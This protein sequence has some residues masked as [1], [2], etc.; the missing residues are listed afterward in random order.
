[1]GDN[2]V[3]RRP[4][5]FLAGLPEP[6][7][8]F[9]V[10]AVGFGL[11]FAA[12]TPPL[13]AP[14]EVAHF[15]RAEGISRGRLRAVRTAAGVGALVPGEVAALVDGPW[16]RLPFHPEASLDVAEVG[17]ALG[18]GY[19]SA[20]S[21]FVPFPATAEY[22]PLPYLPQAAGVAAARVAG[23]PP[24]LQYASGRVAALA[25][26]LALVGLAVRTAPEHRWTIALAAL[27][28]MSLFLAASFSADGATN[29]L[30]FLLL[31]QCLRTRRRTAPMAWR[32]LATVTAVAAGLMLAKP[33]VPLLLLTWLA[34]A[35]RFGSRLRHL[36]FRAAVPCVALLPLAA[37]RLAL[38]GVSPWLPPGV[39]PP[40]QLAWL[41]AHPAAFGRTLAATLAGGLPSWVNGWVGVLGW[42][43]TPLPAALVVAEVGLVLLVGLSERLPAGGTDWGR[44]AILAAA[45]VG[46]AGAVL[47]TLYLRWTPVAA[48]VVDG[49]QGRYFAPLVPVLLAAVP[50][51]LPSLG[52][53]E[54]VVAPALLLQVVVLAVTVAVLVDRYF[55]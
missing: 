27:T 26:W 21:V 50:P 18:A 38:G 42:L 29:G 47:T 7:R 24:L 32:E 5:A 2:G 35:R 28:P 20:R 52:P 4:V 12:V 3:V 6:H 33:Y 54:R 53:G 8:A 22:P 9:L 25:S 37:W 34:P 16:R 23:L 14:D 17:A 49:V 40:D 19:P 11:A 41:L 1:M 15:L 30:A 51:I 13:Q 36:G 55:L 10:V 48:A 44:T 43:D 46:S 39:S 31:A 45:V